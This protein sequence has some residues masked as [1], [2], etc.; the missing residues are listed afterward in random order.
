MSIK[1]IAYVNEKLAA[2][3]EIDVADITNEQLYGF[4]C[5]RAIYEENAGASRWWD[6]WF[7]VTNIDGLLIGFMAARSTG[8]A[9]IYELGWQFNVDSII[10]VEPYEKIT[11]EYRERQ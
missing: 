9:T 5:N 7:Y 11:I 4:L 8:D 3:Y 10:E 6:N 1:T 2:A